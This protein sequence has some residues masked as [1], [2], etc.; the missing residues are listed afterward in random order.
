MEYLRKTATEN[1]IKLGKCREKNGLKYFYLCFSGIE[2]EQIPSAVEYLS[3]IW[4]NDIS[5]GNINES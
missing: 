2:T 4:S 1:G 5:E 3:K